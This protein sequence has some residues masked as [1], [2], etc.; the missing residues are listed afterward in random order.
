MSTDQQVLDTYRRRIE[1]AAIAGL[2]LQPTALDHVR[3]W[4]EPTDFA[5]PHYGDWYT[6]L[7]AMRASGE[8]IDQMTLL[9]ALRR[10]DQLGPQG[11]HADELATITLTTPV[12]A[13]TIEYCRTVLE[14]SIRDQVAGLGIRLTQLAHDGQV[15]GA[16]LLTQAGDLTERTLG[17]LQR[18]LQRT[19][20]R[21]T[22]ISAGGAPAPALHP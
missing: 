5:T 1:A 4:L 8:P 20:Q 21:S 6:H 9:S 15:E 17:P 2:I 18:T 19:Q 3:G 22:G 7:M 16:R 12:P 14:E 10:A 13:S 11:R